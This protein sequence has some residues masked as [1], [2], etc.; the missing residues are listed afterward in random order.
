M[1]TL[2]TFISSFHH[3]CSY[4]IFGKPQSITFSVHRNSC[5]YTHSRTT[6]YYYCFFFCLKKL[7]FSERE[8]LSTGIFVCCWHGVNSYQYVPISK[9][10]W[11]SFIE[12]L[13]DNSSFRLLRIIHN[14]NVEN[15]SK[16]FIFWTQNSTFMTYFLYIYERYRLLK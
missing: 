13:I 6:H 2:T 15:I 9:K 1:H 5:E 14:Y 3:Y 4:V 12:F 16:K 10:C 11:G 8:I 7:F